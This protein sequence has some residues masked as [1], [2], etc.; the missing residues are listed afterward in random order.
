MNYCTNR[1]LRKGSGANRLKAVICGSFRRDPAALRNEFLEL[2]EAGCTVLSPHDLDFVAEADGFVYGR[3]DIGR[4]TAEVEQLHL[5]SMQEAD[6]VWLHCPDGYVG[7]SATMELGFAQALGLRVFSAELPADVALADLVLQCDSP[8]VAVASLKR[9]LRDAPS[10]ALLALQSYYA[11]AAEERGWSGE[12]TALALELLKGEIAELETALKRGSD[13]DSAILELA[14]VQ[15]YVVHLANILGADLGAA[16]RD[17]ERINSERF[18]PAA[19][20]LAA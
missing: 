9:D 7:T 3:N 19:T 5:R 10:Q 13:D 17:K 16:V 14:D 6:F 2:E 20:R 8:R 12:T 11:R 4:S 18:G 1:E 15:L